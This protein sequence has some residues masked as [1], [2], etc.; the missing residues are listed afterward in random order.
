MWWDE[1]SSQPPGR[2]WWWH[3]HFYRAL[4]SPA[5]SQGGSDC[6]FEVNTRQK[7]ALTTQ[8]ISGAIC[9]LCLLLLLGASSLNSSDLCLLSALPTSSQGIFR[10]LDYFSCY[11]FCFN[12]FLSAFIFC[13][14]TFPHLQSY[15]YAS[16]AEAFLRSWDPE[17]F[18][19][20]KVIPWMLMSPKLKEASHVLPLGISLCEASKCFSKCVSKCPQTSAHLWTVCYWSEWKVVEK[21]RP[22]ISLI[23]IAWHCYHI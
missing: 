23:I 19:L 1:P 21:S 22:R 8:A 2:Y 11:H 6:G 7:P 20:W 18:C 14:T 10:S 13:A 16:S 5:L 3:S 4:S 17:Y 12:K 9:L 15:I